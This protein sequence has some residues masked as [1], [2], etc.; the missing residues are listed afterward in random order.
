MGSSSLAVQALDRHHIMTICLNCKHRATLRR[1]A[2]DKNGTCATVRCIATGVSTGE[3]KSLPE[4]V[5]KQQARLNVGGT[6][7]TIDGDRHP[8]NR[9]VNGCFSDL[10]EQ[11]CHFRQP[12][13]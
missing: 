8:P 12:S 3:L 1:A 7:L 5:R 2:V 9:D 13:P 6:L 4:Q 10:F 11:T